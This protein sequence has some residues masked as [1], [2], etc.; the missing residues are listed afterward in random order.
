MPPSILLKP[1]KGWVGIDVRELA[2]YRHLLFAFAARDVKLRYK[3][4]LLGVVWVVLQPIVA[5]GIFS[6]VFGTVAGMR[7]SSG[8]S[9]FAFSFA[10]LLVWNV[11][12]TTLAKAANSMVG[13]TQ[14]VTKV[15]FPRLILPFATVASTLIDFLVPALLL[16]IFL[17]SRGEGGW[18]AVLFPLWV[19]LA[20]LMGL[21]LGL[22]AAALTIE[23]RDIQYILPLVTPFLLYASPV[24]YD[25]SHVPA[26]YRMAYYLVNPMASILEGFR[27]S[28]IGTPPPPLGQ[29]AYA[30][31][32]SLLVFAAGATFFRTRERRAADVI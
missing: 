14:L 15:Y 13:N 21:G 23:Y 18:S 27:W 8:G 10:G 11:F 1:T 30:A 26:H 4:T 12:S 6:F 22:I 29:V 24:A 5:A 19:L 31:G 20:L 32:I 7:T 28:V 2:R 25:V 3:Q 16:A 9:Y 17:A